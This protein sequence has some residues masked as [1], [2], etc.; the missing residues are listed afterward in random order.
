MDILN[1]STDFK[2]DILA[3][4]SGS[5]KYQMV[6][7]EDGTVSFIDVTEYAQVGSTFGAKEV[8][9]IRKAINDLIAE[10]NKKQN[11]ITCGTAEP[12]GGE[13]GDVYIKLE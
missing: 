10:I 7:N 5:R 12:T 4:T 8:N 13:D 11:Q 6:N 9:E 1:L 3:D 2:D